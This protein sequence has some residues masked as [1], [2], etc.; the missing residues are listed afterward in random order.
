MVGVPGVES[1]WKEII[2]K[3]LIIKGMRV[4]VS[5]ASSFPGDSSRPTYFMRYPWGRHTATR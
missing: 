2:L 3:K 1:I 5:H 4:L